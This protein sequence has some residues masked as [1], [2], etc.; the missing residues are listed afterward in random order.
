MLTYVLDLLPLRDITRQSHVAEVAQHRPGMVIQMVMDLSRR[1]FVLMDVDG[2]LPAMTA[3]D[4]LN[5]LDAERRQVVTDYARRVVRQLAFM[6]A[7]FGV[8]P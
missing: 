8:R 6:T 2:I 7:Q 4:M 1:Q 5:E 3:Y